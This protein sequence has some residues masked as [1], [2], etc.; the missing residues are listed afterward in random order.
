MK[1]TKSLISKMYGYSSRTL[2]NLMEDQPEIMNFWGTR[3]TVF[4]MR[5]QRL[6]FNHLGVPFRCERE[7]VEY[8]KFVL[9]Q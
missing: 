4:G 5:Q 3:N 9:N 6:I 8:V 1:I 2:L 7:L